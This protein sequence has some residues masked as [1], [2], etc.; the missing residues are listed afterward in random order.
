MIPSRAF[1]AFDAAA[2]WHPTFRQSQI[3]WLQQ[4]VKPVQPLAMLLARG[5]ADTARERDYIAANNQLREVTKALRR[6]DLNLS[7]P[8]DELCHWCEFRAG[9]AMPLLRAAEQTDRPFTVLR[10]IAKARRLLA[11]YGIELPD[12][13]EHGPLP[14]LRRLTDPAWWRLKVRRL[15]AREVERIAI[16]MRRVRKGREI[17]CSDETVRRRS[18]QKHRN[19]KYLEST[20]A[21]NETADTDAGERKQY[22]LAELSD[23]TVSNPRVR[24]IELMVRV[25]GFDEVAQQLEHV[26][27]FW[28]LTAPSRFHRWRTVGKKG[29]G[30][31]IPNKRWD[32]SMP[33]EAQAWLCDKWAKIRAALAAE[34]VRLYGFRVVEAHHDGTP[35]WHAAI[36]YHPHWQGDEQIDARPLVRSIV[37]RYLLAEERKAHRK[38][39]AAYARAHAK[40][41]KA[42]DRADKAAEKAAA[43]TERAVKTRAR[44]AALAV[45]ADELRAAER[46][47]RAMLGEAAQQLRDAEAHRFDSKAIDPEKGDAAGYLAKYIT[48]A[49]ASGEA[50]DMVQEDLY[51]YDAG[52]SANRVDAWAS[53]NRIRQFQQIGGPSVTTYRECRRAMGREV[54]QA[55]LFDAP[56][57]IQLAAEAADESDWQA[58]VLLMGGPMVKR[59]EQPLRLGYWNEHDAE[60]GEVIGPGVNKYGEVPPARIYGLQYKVPAGW[61]T[62]L[63]RDH[64][65]RHVLTRV[66]TW[67]IHRPGEQ[68][69]AAEPCEQLIAETRAALADAWIGALIIRE[70]GPVTDDDGSDFDFA[71][72]GGGFRFSGGAAAPPLEY[73][74]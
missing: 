47:A 43:T 41:K 32:G 2:D 19:R 6:A 18:A 26:R 66:N 1:L 53:A 60:T 70:A 9:K 71:A 5:Y 62:L 23:L 69:I 3:N 35:H 42:R 13:K 20:T 38:A 31:V 10:Q 24:R 52:E 7:W 64:A 30:A 65:T 72:Y 11:R 48:K 49:I 74:H 56:R 33:W 39:L 8:D 25:R 16:L 37:R 29:D 57:K 44:A 22:T 15:Q 4:V 55:D 63:K 28:T 12:L 68:K 36:F 34:G 50:G 46:A 54:T 59:D 51:G 40:A 67:T 21:V 45:I 58:F 61:T 14:V 17:Y 73:G 27:E